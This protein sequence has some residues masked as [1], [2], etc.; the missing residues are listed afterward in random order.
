MSYKFRLVY[1][2]MLV[3]LDHFPGWTL[4]IKNQIKFNVKLLKI[5]HVWL[6]GFFESR[7]FVGF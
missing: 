5:Y 1:V 7:K 6:T 4:K 3:T 2:C